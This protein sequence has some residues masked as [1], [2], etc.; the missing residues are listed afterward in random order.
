MIFSAGIQLLLYFRWLFKARA[1]AKD[2]HFLATRSTDRFQITM[3]ISTYLALVFMLASYGGWRM[4]VIGH[5][6]VFAI[7]GSSL[8]MV[9]VTNHLKQKKVSAK[10]NRMAT[11]GMAVVFGL[12][13]TG[14]VLY[15]MVSMILDD[16][17]QPENAEPYEYNGWTYYIY[18]DQIPLQIED[19]METEYDHY[20][21]EMI[22]DETS[23]LLSYREVR[24]RTMH[25]APD[26][27]EMEYRIAEVKTPWLYE[28]V[29]N[30]LLDDFDHNYAYPDEPNYVEFQKIDA[31]PWGAKEA[32][33]LLLGGEAQYRY[34]LCYEDTII[35]IDLDWE[36]TTDQMEMIREKLIP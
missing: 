10:V 17:H 16:K 31:A 34:L 21:Y 29:L 6:Q 33:Q 35:E 2:G 3:V 8:L 24:Q 11:Y 30:L 19:L 25:D 4:A 20:S 27:P 12:L 22:T 36:P 1:V 26:E 23:P 32:C 7:L 28:F 9:K 14:C 18:H 5:L 15:F 13:I